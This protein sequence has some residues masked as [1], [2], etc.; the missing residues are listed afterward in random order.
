MTAATADI[1]TPEIKSPRFLAGKFTVLNDAVLFAGAML[2]L[3][4]ADEIQPAADTAGLRVIGRC[5]L[6]MDNAADGL[7][8]QVEQGLFQYA[9]SATYPVPRSAI[10][11]VCYV[12]D[13]ATVGGFSTN[14]VPAGIVYDVDDDGVWVDQRPA[15]LAA[16]VERVPKVL[17]A[18]SGDYTVTA[19]LAFQ[20]R[21][22]F[23]MTKSGG[24][25]LTLPSAVA[26][27]RVGVMRGS[28]TATDDVSVQ[29]ATG[30]KV[31]G[32]DALSAASKKIENTVD[33]ISGILWLRAVDDTI[34]AIDN[35]L[36]A[37]VASWVKNDA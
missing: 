16:A 26:G 2:A 1:D 24:L 8:S 11:Q 33:A 30:D 25:T 29:A 7:T 21:S 19:A 15:A 3:D 27:M 18:K 10:G 37:D 32:Y 6:G 13:D 22:A 14:L 20:G 31:Q 28:A 17:V 12:E 34:W 4:Y 35:P 36:P 5:P 23:K 9:N